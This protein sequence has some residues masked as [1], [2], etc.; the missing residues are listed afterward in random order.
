MSVR[1]RCLPKT[2]ANTFGVLLGSQRNDV[3]MLNYYDGGIGPSVYKGLFNPDNFYPYKTYYAFKSFNE[4]YKLGLEVSSDSSNADVYVIAAKSEGRGVILVANT[5][6]EPLTLDIE[7]LGADINSADVIITD[8]EYLYTF[9]G[10]IIRNG[11]LNIKEY[12]CI[13][14]R[15]KL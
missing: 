8:D 3:A 9:V 7:A 4:A 12:S 14:I 11:K 5:T 1:N 13:E 15:V 10:D 6:D 2:A